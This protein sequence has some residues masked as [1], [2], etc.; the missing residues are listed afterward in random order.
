MNRKY[1]LLVDETENSQRANDLLKRLE[2]E[3]D[4]VRFKTDGEINPPI[5][6]IPEGHLEGLNLITDYALTAYT[7]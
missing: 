5:L 6:F 4:T 7:I 3:F 1:T 2:V